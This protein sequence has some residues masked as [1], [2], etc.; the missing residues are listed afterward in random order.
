MSD[1]QIQDWQE[2]VRSTFGEQSRMYEYLFETMDNFYYRYLET[3]TDKNLK[4]SA[5]GPHLWGARSYESS[6]VDALKITN[7][8]AKKGIIELAKNVPKAQGPRV[9]YE[10]LA[11]VEELNAEKGEI[12]IIAVINWGH[13]D[14]DK[15]DKQFRKAVIFKY[16]DL[17]Q[18][19]KELALKLEEVCEAFL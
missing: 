8:V 18:F 14:F 16:S 17:A 13:P 2:K 3:T 19:R 11:N 7:P 12:H 9:Q 5:L 10:L 1:K 6:M 15:A 4:T